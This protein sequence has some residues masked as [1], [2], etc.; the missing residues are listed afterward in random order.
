MSCFLYHS[1]ILQ[2]LIVSVFHLSPATPNVAVDGGQLTAARHPVSVLNE[3]GQKNNLKV[4]YK[5][6]GSHLDENGQFYLFPMMVQLLAISNSG[7]QGS[8]GPTKI[9]L[10]WTLCKW[11]VPLN[12]LCPYSSWKPAYEFCPD[13]LL[14]PCWHPLYKL[15]TIQTF[16]L[17]FWT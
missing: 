12:R 14:I 10:Q 2:Y 5:V 13:F 1:V 7:M 9:L 6:Q 8:K 15:Y 17:S 4:Q 3:Y 11:G 16:N